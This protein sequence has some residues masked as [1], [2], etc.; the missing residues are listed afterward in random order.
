VAW[1]VEHAGTVAVLRFTRPP[2][3]LMSFE[4][5]AEL[6]ALLQAV[7]EDRGVHAVLLAS[8]LPGYFVGH[9]D[10][11]DVQGLVDGT[12]GAGTPDWWLATLERLGAI[13]TPVIAAVDG[14]AWGGGCELALA[15]Q[16][17]V[18]SSNTHFAFVEV[19]AGAIPG[20]GGTQRLPRL[21]GPAAAAQMVLSGQ[22]VHADEALRIGLVNAVLTGEDFLAAALDW[23][24]PIAEQ[25]R[26]TLVAAKRAL[27][28]G[29]RMPLAEGLAYEQRIFRS[30]LRSPQSQ[31]MF[32]SGQGADGA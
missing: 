23:V 10:L 27:L 29:L 19:G 6:D 30:V 20:A 11:D 8:G 4:L 2:E 31:A 18:A 12:L 15:C 17:R 7:G 21:V 28:D 3:N 9:A 25:P 22:V 26:H 16:M 13:D 24:R 32:A 1:T 14:Q 5:L